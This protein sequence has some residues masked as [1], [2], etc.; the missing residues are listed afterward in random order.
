MSMHVVIPVKRNTPARVI[1]LALTV[2]ASIGIMWLIVG[3]V[4]VIVLSAEL[5]V[6]GRLLLRA[7][8]GD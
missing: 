8:H 5:F 3:W 6:L 7:A 4:G 2:L 1:G